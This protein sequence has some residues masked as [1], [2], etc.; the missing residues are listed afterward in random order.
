MPQKTQKFL[1]VG[2]IQSERQPAI[3]LIEQPNACVMKSMRIACETI[4]KP[5]S[6]WG[7]IWSRQRNYSA[8]LV[9]V[10]LR[11]R[12]RARERATETHWLRLIGIQSGRPGDRP[13]RDAGDLI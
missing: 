8:G 9:S 3:E 12:Q 7:L 2:R 4:C 11:E 1:T 13:P 5:A 10:R 6:G